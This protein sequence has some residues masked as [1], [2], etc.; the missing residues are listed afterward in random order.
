MTATQTD[1]PRAGSN[2]FSAAIAARDVDALVDAL[3]PEPVLHSAVTRAPFRGRRLLADLYGSLFEAF[4]EVRIVDELDSGDTHVFF[5]EGR[6]DGRYVAGADR[7]RLD[8]NGKVREITVVGRPLSGLSTFLTG[9]GFRLAQRRRGTLVAWLLRLTALPL[10]PLFS[11]LDP[12]T[13]W[14]V[15]E[16]GTQAS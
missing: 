3:A 11:L 2:P 15:R 16:R 10:A 5:W 13:R 4:E 9:I 6:M 1:H 8:S 14:L 7:L 12:V